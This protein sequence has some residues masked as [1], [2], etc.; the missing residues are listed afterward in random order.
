M[1]YEYEPGR[2][3]LTAPPDYPGPQGTIPP[4]SCSTGTPTLGFRQLFWGLRYHIVALR[5]QICLDMQ[6]LLVATTTAQE[7][8]LMKE[9]HEKSLYQAG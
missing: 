1:R 8:G 9:W 4:F 7:H 3:V 6:A 2:P 5:L